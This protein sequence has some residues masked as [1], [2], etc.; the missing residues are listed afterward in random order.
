MAP[1][2]PPPAIAAVIFDLDGTLLNTEPFYYEVERIMIS[3]LCP[4]RSV[5]EVFSE[6]VG[7]TA[8]ATA[9]KLVAH[10][11]LS[12]SPAQYLAERDEL[13]AQRFA[14]TELM[15]GARRL[16]DHLTAHG[17]PKGV[18]TSSTLKNVR[19]KTASMA[20]WFAAAFPVLVTGE[21]AKRGKPAP[22]IFELAAD[23]LG[24]P[25]A[26]RGAVLVFEDSV[27]GLRGAK[28]AGMKVAA[29][30]DAHNRFLR[31]ADY[32]EADLLVDSLEE[33][34]PERWGLPPFGPPP[35]PAAPPRS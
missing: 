33:F 20:A 1:A 13:L 9:E 31:R 16:V 30:F 17:I 14:R 23:R 19:L 8:Q 12:L 15:P 35:A 24:V 22:D 5:D 3:R 11:N 27:A 25:P 21:E 4:G 34:T 7:I 18:A 2:A 28:A 10:F 32:A 29:V 6:L 26:E